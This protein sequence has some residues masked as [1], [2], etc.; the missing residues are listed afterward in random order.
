[1][2]D[3]VIE[4]VKGVLIEVLYY[5]RLGHLIGKGGGVNSGAVL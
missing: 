3:E 5:G 1:M 4:L 2:V